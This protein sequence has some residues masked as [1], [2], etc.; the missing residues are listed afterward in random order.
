L[1]FA[2]S[3]DAPRRDAVV[4][5]APAHSHMWFAPRSCPEKIG[6]RV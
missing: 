2:M 4:V 5:I 1:S 6:A 3:D